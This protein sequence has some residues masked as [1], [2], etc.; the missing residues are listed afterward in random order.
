MIHAHDDRGVLEL[1]LAR[2]DRRNALTPEGLAEL[3]RIVGDQLPEYARCILLH[4]H[5]KAFCA[6]FD[7]DL[8]RDHPDGSMMR[9]LLT[10]L[11]KAILALRTARAPV[12]MAAHGAAVAGGCALLGGAD[13]IVANRAAKFGYPVV[14]LGISPA[15]SAP[16]IRRSLADG[17]TRERALDT[18]LIDAIEAHRIGLVHELVATPDDVLPRARAIA[19]ELAAKPPHALAATRAW[20][21]AID[22]HAGLFERTPHAPPTIHAPHLPIPDPRAKNALGLEASLALTGGEEERRLLAA[23]WAR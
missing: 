19:H 6:G 7:L 20:M 12:V 4:G 16:F 21:A 3:A 22:E 5:G 15:V 10:G 11:A 17:H 9:T 1:A 18:Q 23:L 13:F 8:C 14:R 2:P